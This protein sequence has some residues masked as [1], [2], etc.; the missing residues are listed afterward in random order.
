ML[1]RQFATIFIL[2]HVFEWNKTEYFFDFLGDQFNKALH[3]GDF[4]MAYIKSKLTLGL[5]ACLM[6]ISGLIVNLFIHKIKF[7]H[8]FVIFH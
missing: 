4:T 2:I 8:L 7:N 3:H 5:Y 6:H 1:D